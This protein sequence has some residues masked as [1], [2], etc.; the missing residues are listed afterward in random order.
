MRRKLLAVTIVLLFTSSYNLFAQKKD[1]SYAQLFQS[2]PTDISKSLPSVGKWVDDEHYLENR[3]DESDGKMKLMSVDVKPG[4]SFGVPQ[5][6]FQAPIYGGGATNG[7]IRWDVTG[8]GQ[9]F[10]INTVT[11]DASTPLTV[12]LNWQAGL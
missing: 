1:F 3:K 11:G 12:V 10:L 5:E 6:L 7:Q 9:K 4:P 2:A 8:N